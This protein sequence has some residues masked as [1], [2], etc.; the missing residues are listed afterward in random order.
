MALTST[1]TRAFGGTRLMSTLPSEPECQR[2]TGN[3]QI[4][5]SLQDFSLAVMLRRCDERINTQLRDTYENYLHYQFRSDLYMAHHDKHIK[6]YRLKRDDIRNG[7]T[8]AAGESSKI[9]RLQ[10]ALQEFDENFDV[11]S[12]STGHMP[13][14]SRSILTTGST[15]RGLSLRARA[16]SSVSCRS[17]E[18]VQDVWHGAADHSTAPELEIKGQDMH[19]VLKVVLQPWPTLVG[20]KSLIEYTAEYKVGETYF[21]ADWFCNRNHDSLRDRR[22]IRQRA[23]DRASRSNDGQIIPVHE[24]EPFVYKRQSPRTLAQINSDLVTGSFVSFITLY[25]ALPDRGVTLRS[26][27]SVAG[28]EAGY[29]DTVDGDYSD[30]SKAYGIY[31]S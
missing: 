7:V 19:R 5:V 15:G 31:K 11:L 30:F 16:C 22:A 27:F 6:E 25:F 21:L 3:Q 29:S 8:D 24:C 12:T 23:L 28:S 14:S 9:P 20:M 2:G 18:D 26:R 17:G 1:M 13:E 10:K 4:A